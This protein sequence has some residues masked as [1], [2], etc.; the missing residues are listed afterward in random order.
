[1][2]SMQTKKAGPGYTA[3]KLTPESLAKLRMLAAMQG[4]SVAEVAGEMAALG[5]DEYMKG[6]KLDKSAVSAIE[7][8]A[9][10]K[11]MQEARV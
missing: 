5:L 6:G 3:T 2:A 1:M 9:D 7:A 11:A 4:K 10:F 8:A